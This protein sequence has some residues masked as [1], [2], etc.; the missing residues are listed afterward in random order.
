MFDHCP[1]SLPAAI[2]VVPE[3]SLLQTIHTSKLLTCHM[4][5]CVNMTNKDVFVIQ[6]GSLYGD[7]ATSTSRHLLNK[8]SLQHWFYTVYFGCVAKCT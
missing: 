2:R 3:P 7:D 8:E 5:L 6:S 4:F 1:H